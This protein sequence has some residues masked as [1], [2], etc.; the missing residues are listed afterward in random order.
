MNELKISKSYLEN[1]IGKEVSSISYPYGKYN[2]IVKQKVFDAGYKLGFSSD[3]YFNETNQ[4][5]LLLCRC[6]IWNSDFLDIFKDKPY[7]FNLGH[8]VLPNTDPSM[9]D[10]L[11]K[12]IKNY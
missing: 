5:K 3:F 6:E 8:G 2:S 11:V 10:Y 9:V 4:D 12:L 7:I 1:L